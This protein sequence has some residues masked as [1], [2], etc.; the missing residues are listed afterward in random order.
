VGGRLEYELLNAPAAL[1]GTTGRVASKSLM[2]AYGRIWASGANL[3]VHRTA[4]VAV[5]GFDRDLELGCEDMDFCIRAS[6]AGFKIGFAPDAVVHYRLR[7]E[8][9]PLLRQKFVM[10]VGG[11]HLYAKHH[12]AGNL[13][14]YP[15][16]IRRNQAVH[17][18]WHVV[19]R[20]PQLLFPRSRWAY[21]GQVA[22]GVGRIVGWWRYSGPQA[23]GAARS[24]TR[25]DTS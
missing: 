16:R 19:T 18:L 9:S 21:L 4:L 8:L 3:G 7:S 5:G 13:D 20:S 10:G 12:A 25:P 22:K 11:A 24:L 23:L 2:R 6:D 1:R 14:G 15:P 17:D